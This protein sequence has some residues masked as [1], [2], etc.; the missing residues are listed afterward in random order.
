MRINSRK[1]KSCDSAP[2]QSTPEGTAP[3]S[4]SFSFDFGKLHVERQ[5]KDGVVVAVGPMLARTLEAVEGM[6]LTVLYAT[7][8]VP[9][10]EETLKEAVSQAAPHV[11]LVEPYYEGGLVQDIAKTLRATADRMEAIGVPRQD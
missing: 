3:C 11:I 7:T 2:F 1:R 10:D 6:D 4:R 8:V 5:G 9:F